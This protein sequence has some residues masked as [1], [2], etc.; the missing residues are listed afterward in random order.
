MKLQNDPLILK[1]AGHLKNSTAVLYPIQNLQYSRLYVVPND[2]L[3]AQQYLWRLVWVG[4]QTTF[5][6][7]TQTQMD[8]W[9][10][11]AKK[12]FQTSNPYGRN[13]P[14][15][16]RE[17]F[18]KVN[19]AYF[20]RSEEWTPT[21]PTSAPPL[22]PL[23]FAWVYPSGGLATSVALYITHAIAPYTNY[24]VAMRITPKLIPATRPGNRRALR[25]CKGVSSASSRPLSWSG[26]YAQ[27]DGLGN[28]YSV[29]DKALIELTIISPQGVP[30][31][32]L[33][34]RKTRDS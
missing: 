33:L 13:R 34:F 27:W 18:F 30:S 17:T 22:H 4:I 29:G 24:K 9:T 23:R 21:C 28:S 7:L 1:Q 25:W 5:A 12:Y 10:A 19:L 16:A 15:T 32:P 3:S 26:G 2:P 20:M 6:S 14:L 11:Y 31:V 8:A